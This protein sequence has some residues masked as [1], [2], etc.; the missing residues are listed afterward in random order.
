MYSLPIVH[1]EMVNILCAVTFFRRLWA[2]RHGLV[3]CDNQALVQVLSAGRA[4]N[5]FLAAC[6]RNIW[7]VLKI[8]IGHMCMF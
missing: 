1:L 7:Q 6:A 2:N 4:R 3:K 8:L 5:S